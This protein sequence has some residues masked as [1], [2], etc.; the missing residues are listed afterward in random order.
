MSVPSS[1]AY[2]AGPVLIVDMPAARHR[3]LLLTL[4]LSP[5]I[6]ES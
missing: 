3:S 1:R 5:N 6:D 2:D 4:W